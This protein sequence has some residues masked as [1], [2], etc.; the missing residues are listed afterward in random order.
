MEIK[1][2]ANASSSGWWSNSSS[3]SHGICQQNFV[4]RNGGSD[5]ATSISFRSLR[6]KLF[7]PA[8]QF[9]TFLNIN[10][11][12]TDERC[13]VAQW[14]WEFIT[15]NVTNCAARRRKNVNDWLSDEC[16]RDLRP[17]HDNVEMLFSFLRYLRCCIAAQLK[18]ANTCPMAQAST[19]PTTAASTFPI[20]VD[21]TT[22]A[23]VSMYR[24][25][26]ASTSTTTEA[27]TSTLKGKNARAL[28]QP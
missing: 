18:R 11:R 9:W 21:S 16:K 6:A 8:N 13:S 14:Q 10:R 5:E 3:T 23:A 19:Y 28:N 22:E 26:R 25:T 12:L 2:K 1:A 24:T 7:R 4:F 17:S 27:N 20:T 15:H